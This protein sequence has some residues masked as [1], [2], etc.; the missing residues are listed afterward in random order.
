MTNA[1]E[2]IDELA[3]HT[4]IN[5]E[6]NSAGKI[7][8]VEKFDC[9]SLLYDQIIVKRTFCPVTAKH[10][11]KN[12]QAV[13]SADAWKVYMKVDLNVEE[14]NKIICAADDPCGELRNYMVEKLVN[15]KLVNTNVGDNEIASGQ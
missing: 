11:L 3:K 15:R 9:V 5:W 8:S 12:N 1:I 2:F 13:C 6:I 14:M 4:E 7:R 10:Y